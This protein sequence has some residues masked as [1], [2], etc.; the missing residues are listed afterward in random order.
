MRLHRKIIGHSVPLNKM[1]VAG[2][3]VYDIPTFGG[4][5]TFG[6]STLLSWTVWSVGSARKILLNAGGG[7]DSDTF[8]GL[9]A[10]GMH[11]E[12]LFGHP[13][14]GSANKL[15]MDKQIQPLTN[16]E[17]TSVRSYAPIF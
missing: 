15:T 1:L 16:L 5:F 14:N 4:A 2:G 6:A 11:V 8:V 7:A 9:L 17:N 3:G 13:I 10:F 12:P